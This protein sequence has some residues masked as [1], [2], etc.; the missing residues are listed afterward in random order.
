MMVQSPHRVD[1]VGGAHPTG[2]RVER[3][4]QRAGKGIRQDWAPRRSSHTSVGR[5]H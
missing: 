5:L 2:E 3:L 1:D 4:H